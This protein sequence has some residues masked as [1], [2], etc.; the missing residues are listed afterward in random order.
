MKDVQPLRVDDGLSDSSI[1][2]IQQFL[3]RVPLD[4]ATSCLEAAISAATPM[5]A[6]LM[7][8]VAEH[9]AKLPHC[10]NELM[11][12]SE[13]ACHVRSSIIRFQIRPHV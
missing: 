7:S 1:Q 12:K 2:H 8:H 11:S 4:S 6:V 3:E 13:A 9:F 5:D 10:L